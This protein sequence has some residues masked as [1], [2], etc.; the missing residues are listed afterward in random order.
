MS[1]RSNS[2]TPFSSLMM[3]AVVVSFI[4][5]PLNA[6]PVDGNSKSV[7]SRFLKKPTNNQSAQ[8]RDHSKSVFNYQN[9]HQRLDAMIS[10]ARQYEQHNQLQHAVQMYLDVLAINPSVPVAQHRLAVNLDILGH[11]D[12]ARQHYLAAIQLAP[13]NAE[14]FC[15]YGYSLYLQG[16]LQ[17]AARYYQ[18]AINLNRNLRR[19]YNNLGMLYAL[20]NQPDAAIHQFAYAGCHPNQAQLNLEFAAKLAGTITDRQQPNVSPQQTVQQ[21][22]P[23]RYFDSEDSKTPG[24]QTQHENLPVQ[25]ASWNSPV[26]RAES[27][28]QNARYR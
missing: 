1:K 6:S 28:H 22:S 23:P 17:E 15:D 20:N 4:S 10:E 12:I 2:V 9:S 27:A 3:F 25:Q 18:H 14:V 8:R 11:G 16:D 24:Y 13:R 19:A 7:F 21:A 5:P 26:Q